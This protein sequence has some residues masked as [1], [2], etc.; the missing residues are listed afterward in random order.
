M[1][2]GEL[3]VRD[4]VTATPD[5]SVVDAARRMAE[6]GVGN[7]IVVREEPP[8]QPQPLGIVTDRD[9]VVEVLAHPDRVPA[10]TTIG[11]V[12]RHALVVAHEDDDIEGVLAK[13]RDRAIRRIPVVDVAGGLQGML[14]IDDVLGWMR[15]QLQAATR[16]LERQGRGPGQ[17]SP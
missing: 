3:C 16:I 5:E 6:Y 4:V 7:L 2:A 12:M 1:R 15:D 11:D 14:T 8:A 17:V 10:T 9:L 13:M